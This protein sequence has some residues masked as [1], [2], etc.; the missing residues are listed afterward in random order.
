MMSPRIVYLVTEDWYFASHRLP[1]ARA[2][3][4]AGFDVHVA[5]QVERHGAAI[6][7]EGFQVH[8]LSQKRGSFDP[9][10]IFH[11]VREIRKLYRS[12]KPDLAHHVALRP[13][14][15]GS[16]AALGLPVTC[17]NAITGLG[18]AFIG[19]STKLRMARMALSVASRP[20][21]NRA[22]SAV[23]VQNPDDRAT[24]EQL[25]IDP[26]RITLIPGSG[27]DIRAMTP[28][29]EPAGPVTIA[30]VGRL[31]DD[32]GIRV[33]V[34]A[35]AILCQR[36]RDIRLLIAGMPDPANP[37]SIPAAEIENW[38]SRPNLVHLGFVE[39]IAGLWSAANIAVLPSRREGLPL[40]L[41]EAAACGR[42]LVATDVPGC[43]EIARQDVNALL[44]PPDNP[45]ALADA[46][47]RLAA[48]P[49]LRRKFGAASRQIVEEEFSDKR[50]GRDTVALYRR[51][52]H[53]VTQ[54]SG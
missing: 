6:A 46:I 18:T 48:D 50:V 25:G 3:R 10:Q 9:S 19:D 36:G 21:L 13:C 38:R 47:D 23:L 43:R 7:A 28:K 49:V 32:K 2:A 42:P 11:A 35:H 12:I 37:T 15:L 14:M 20:L 17:L 16:F 39:D 26:N 30:F 31:L 22:R 54:S 34:A 52:L 5:T 41:L 51:L 44:V 4:E 24:V 27:V 1:M 33:L 45:Q 8:P 40:S 29:P 53:G